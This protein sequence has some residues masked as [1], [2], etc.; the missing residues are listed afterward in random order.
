MKYEAELFVQDNEGDKANEPSMRFAY[1]VFRSM[2]GVE[3]V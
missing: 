1:L 2:D 3:G